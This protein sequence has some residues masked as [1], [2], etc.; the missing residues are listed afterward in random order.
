MILAG[1]RCVAGAD[2]GEALLV[3]R[4][5]AG[6]GEAFGLLV[7]PHLG[8]P[9]RLCPQGGPRDGRGGG[10]RT[11]NVTAQ[12]PVP[13][14]WEAAGW[15]EEQ[16]Q[17]EPADRLGWAD[18]TTRSWADVGRFALIAAGGRDQGELTRAAT[19]G[20]WRCGAVLTGRDGVAGSSSARAP[21]RKG[22]PWKA[23]R[24]QS[25]TGRPCFL[26]VEM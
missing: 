16:G 18:S 2:A 24:S 9:L 5:R 23:C 3:D 1:G 4:A 21:G 7:R 22:C 20:S 12:V 6:D 8:S 17:C 15:G 13:G 26:T 25:R 10:H 19:G 14:G 11:G